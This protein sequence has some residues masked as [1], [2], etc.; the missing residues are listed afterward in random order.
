MLLEDRLETHEQ[1]PELIVHAG[2]NR[3]EMVNFHLVGPLH[4]FD[5]A[6]VD[7][8]SPLMNELRHLIA[9][10]LQRQEPLWGRFLA[11]GRCAELREFLLQ[12]VTRGIEIHVEGYEPPAEVEGVDPSARTAGPPEG[13]GGV[14]TM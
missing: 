11:T 12:L 10:L 14:Q 2:A 13:A 8:R 4:D 6:A 1:A 7:R 3:G 9:E 5:E